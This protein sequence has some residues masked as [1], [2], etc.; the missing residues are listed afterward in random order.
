MLHYLPELLTIAVIHFFALISPGPDFALVLKNSIGHSRSAGI[1]TALGIA[2]G[3]TV[4]VTYSLIGI[5]I[6]IAQSIALFSIIKL[7]G[8][9]YLVYIGWKALHAKKQDVSKVT[10]PV[11]LS[12]GAAIRM[13]FLTNVLNPKVTLFFL[14]IFTQVVHPGTPFAIRLLFGGEIICMSLVLWTLI[15]F[16]FSHHLIKNRFTR[17]QHYFEHTMGAILIALGIKVALST[18]K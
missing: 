11:Q 2:L 13:G 1:Y 6:L 15:A 8:A 18:A 16:L 3:L 9:G 4:H 5:G 17:I 12:N 10:A 14:G 7:L